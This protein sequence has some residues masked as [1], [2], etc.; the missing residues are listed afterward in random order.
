MVAVGDALALAGAFAALLAD[1][2]ARERMGRAAR[3]TIEAEHSLERSMAQLEAL[4]QEVR[5]ER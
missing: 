3:E 5:A 4:L 1:R 2:G